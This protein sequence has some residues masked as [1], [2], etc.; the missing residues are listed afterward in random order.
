MRIDGAEDVVEEVDIGVLVDC[1]G[2][3]D[4]LLLAAAEVDAAL[5]DLGLVAE[6]HHL[7]VLLEAADADDLLVPLPVHRRSEQDVVLDGAV[8]DP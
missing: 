2:E 5:A 8:L 1:S 7:E 6:L 4:A 3:L